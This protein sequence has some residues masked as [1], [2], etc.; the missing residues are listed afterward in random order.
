MKEVISEEIETW[1]A[2]FWLPDYIFEDPTDIHV[3]FIDYKKQTIYKEV[4][5]DWI[6]KGKR[7]TD[8]I[9][10]KTEWRVLVIYRDYKRTTYYEWG[11]P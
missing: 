2:E 9:L 5:K 3:R 11:P 4:P 7:P 1:T 6:L 8:N 10:V